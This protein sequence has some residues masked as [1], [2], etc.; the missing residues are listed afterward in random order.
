M[1]QFVPVVVRIMK[2]QAI[3]AMP[4]DTPKAD[5]R[6]Q[7]ADSGDAD[8][9][10][11]EI[12]STHEPVSAAGDLQATVAREDTAAVEQTETIGTYVRTMEAPDSEPKLDALI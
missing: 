4:A 3:E 11:M 9:A 8:G 6:A 5:P 10:A 7:P 12:G 2:D 1:V